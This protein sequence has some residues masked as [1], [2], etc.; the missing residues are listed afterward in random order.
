[1]IIEMQN[2]KIGTLKVPGIPIKLSK[3][4]G[5]INKFAPSLGEQTEEILKKYLDF[6]S[7]K[8]SELR[9]QGVI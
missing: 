6:D 8:I 3:T 5:N 4:P 7:K 2:E 9:R 1:M